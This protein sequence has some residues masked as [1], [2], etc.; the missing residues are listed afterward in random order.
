MQ[1]KE[2]FIRNWIFLTRNRRSM[3]AVVFNSLIVS[4]M[5]LSVFW[6]VCDFPDIIGLE[7]KDVVVKYRAYL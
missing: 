5:M 4:L 2:I 7:R 6:K 1:F 3:A